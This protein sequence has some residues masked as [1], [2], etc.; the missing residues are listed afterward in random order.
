MS[1]GKIP[2][3]RNKNKP[4][5]RKLEKGEGS[6]IFKGKPSIAPVGSNTMIKP[7]GMAL[8]I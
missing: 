4:G 8:A 7:A 3:I 2:S 1:A 6:K 5:M